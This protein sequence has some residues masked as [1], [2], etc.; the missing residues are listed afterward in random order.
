MSSLTTLLSLALSKP[1]YV[2]G[3]RVDQNQARLTIS[4]P[5]LSLQTRHMLLFDGDNKTESLTDQILDGE[6]RLVVF[7]HTHCFQCNLYDYSVDRVF[8]ASR[9]ACI[10]IEMK[11]AVRKGYL[12]AL[13]AGSRAQKWQCCILLSNFLLRRAAR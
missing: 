1:G 12:E 10:R 13:R 11:V 2:S 5:V 3:V 6:V 9:L 4:A 8:S 7:P